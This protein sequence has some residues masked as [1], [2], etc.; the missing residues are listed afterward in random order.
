VG[1]G[2]EEEHYI[3][4]VNS[5]IPMYEV[6]CSPL[7]EAGHQRAVGRIKFAGLISSEHDVEAFPCKIVQPRKVGFLN[8]FK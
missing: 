4:I 8:F 7:A 1:I 5:A 6:L 2:G 3:E